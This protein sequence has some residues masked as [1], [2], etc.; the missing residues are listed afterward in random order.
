MNIYVWGIGRIAEKICGTLRCEPAGFVDSNKENWG[1][2]FCGRVVHA[3]QD[4]FDGKLPH[5]DCIILSA[6]TYEGIVYHIGQLHR[7]GKTPK[8]LPFWGEDEPSENDI[9]EIIDKKEWRIAV[10]E[11][12]LRALEKRLS[13]RLANYGYEFAD[14]IN[15]TGYWF[16]RIRDSGEAVEKIVN[17][18]CSL[19]R[20]GD[21]EFEIMAGKNRAPFQECEDDL[22]LRL[23]ETVN[24]VH[25]KILI[26]IADNYGEL[27]K[28]TDTV[29]DGIRA[30]MT[31]DVR[32]FHASVL[33]PDRTYYDAYLFKAYLP[34]RDKSFTKK[35]V[36]RMKRIW[37]KR[38][39]VLIEGEF[40]RTGYGNDLMDNAKSI[41]RILCPTKNAWGK[42]ERILE[43]ARKADRENLI[44]IALGPAGKVLAYDLA[45]IGFQAVDIGQADM[46]YD[47]QIAGVGQRVPNPWKYVS[48]L[49]PTEI[50]EVSDAR[51]LSQVIVRIA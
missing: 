15:R 19:I 7:D 29:A 38:D 5:P 10:L 42:Y 13:M 47:W 36:E 1:R 16:P 34:Y 30:Y 50:R 35:R 17:E 23:R 45:R 22:S 33:Q 20:F 44:L 9:S 6:R 40:T 48:Q 43:E 21:G 26:A 14:R 25:P 28:Y 51:Y 27:S 8:I 4:M 39:V 46:D 31:D 32:R 49:P 2:E 11:E 12:R 37:E 41:R 3:P 24:V 18:G